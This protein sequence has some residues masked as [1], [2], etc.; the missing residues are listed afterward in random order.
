VTSLAAEAGLLKYIEGV[1]DG[2]RSVIEDG[3]ALK[4][5]GIVFS[6]KD[7]ETGVS[8]TEPLPLA[9]P[10]TTATFDPA[11]R[12]VYAARLRAA[13]AETHA[14]GMMFVHESW[15]RWCKEGNAA[16]ERHEC[17]FAVVDHKAT[18]Q[19]CW[20]AYIDRTGDTPKL[21]KHMSLTDAANAAGFA[22]GQANAKGAVGRF[23]RIMPK[24]W[25][26]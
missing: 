18:E 24:R 5:L 8:L 4:P 23:S 26:N 12:Q 1:F 16:G 6:L 15:F 13:A 19:R 25:M 3:S 2:A 9:V 11:E 22:V 17:V 21:G 20:V 14:C 10:V 7:P